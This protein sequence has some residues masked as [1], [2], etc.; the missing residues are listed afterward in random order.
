MFGRTV[1]KKPLSVLITSGGTTEYIDDVRVLTNIS[2]GR[3]GAEIASALLWNF[4]SVTYV[5]GKNTALPRTS[6]IGK[7]YEYKFPVKFIEARDVAALMKIMEE[8]VP[9][10]DVVIHA[11]AVSDFTFDR[12]EPIKL[13]SNDKAAFVEHLGRTIRDNPKVISYIKKWNPHCKLIGFKFEVGK[14]TNELVQIAR[15]MGKN[16]GC[17]LV[18]ANDKTEMVREKEHVA[19]FVHTG[20]YPSFDVARGKPAIAKKLVEYVES[21]SKN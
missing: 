4:T 11:M 1:I 7:D 5:H 9:K 8:E 20:D 18:I 6:D 21:L 19:Y 14:N 10:H 15:S 2:T 16:N 3:L 12:S 13:K 17:D